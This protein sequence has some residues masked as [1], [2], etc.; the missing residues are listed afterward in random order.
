MVSSF[1]VQLIPLNTECSVE[2]GDFV[3]FT[4]QPIYE[5][6]GAIVNSALEKH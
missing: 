2:L 3:Q 5:K 1:Y 4:A 6:Y